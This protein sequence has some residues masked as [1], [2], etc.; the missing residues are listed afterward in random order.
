MSVGERRILAGCEFAPMARAQV[1]SVIRNDKTAPNWAGRFDQIFLNVAAD[2]YLTL[3][4]YGLIDDG[5][6]FLPAFS[7]L[8]QPAT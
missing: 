6:G 2:Q 1:A 4:P 8:R 5:S 3:Q 7:A